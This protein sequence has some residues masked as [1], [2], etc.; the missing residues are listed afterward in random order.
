MLVGSAAFGSANSRPVALAA[1]LG[2]FIPD[3]SLYVL[4]G[5]SIFILG[6]SPHVVF[7]ELYFSDSWQTVFSIDNS[8]VLWGV[9][10]AIALAR[11]QPVFV[12]FTAS[13]LLHLL[14]DFT[15]HHDDAR[16]HFWP[17]TDWRF[18]S[19]V[20]YWDSAHHAAWAAPLEG[21]VAF[22]CGVLLWLRHAKPMVRVGV[23]MLVFVELLIIRQWLM[24]F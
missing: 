22:A 5:V 6:I 18:A 7:D 19:P 4:C 23:A 17:I 21:L 20:S 3:I 11:K 14:T 8:F 9:L 10:S 15:L 13:A 16:A 12:V 2:A 24:F 1:L